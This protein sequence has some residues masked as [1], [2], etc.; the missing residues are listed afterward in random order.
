MTSTKQ[1]EYD[2]EAFTLGTNSDINS[3]QRMVDEYVSLLDR[4]AK[5]EALLKQLKEQARDLEWNKLPAVMTANG[6]RSIDRDDGTSVEVVEEVTG[7]IPEKN[8]RDAIMW[9]RTNGHGGIVQQTLF[10]TFKK[11]EEKLAD[12]ARAVLEKNGYHPDEKATVNHMT[13]KAW[14]REMVSR[15]TA[16]PTELLG[17]FIGQRTKIKLPKE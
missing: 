11:G 16:L 7:S 3:V 8:L 10:M 14:A 4:I 2:G 17:L 1:L 5:G 15:G 13:L 9:L 12:G 6:V